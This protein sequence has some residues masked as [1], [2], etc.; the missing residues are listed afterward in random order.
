L[1]SAGLKPALLTSAQRAALFRALARLEDSGIPANRAV[2][3]MA[4]LLGGGHVHRFRSMSTA[5]AGGASITEAGS[6]FGL[7]SARDRE[8]IRLAER[9]GTLARAATLLADAYDHRARVFAAL[10]SRM[11]LPLFVLVLGSVLLPL[12]AFL[13]GQMGAGEFLWR[14]STPVAGLV[15]VAGLVTRLLRRTA[16]RGVSPAGG[17][18]LLWLPVLSQALAQVNR[19][20]LTEGLT[21]LLHAGV[22]VKEALQGAL[23]SLTNPAARSVYAPALPRLEEAGLSRALSSV[24]VL[25]ADEFAVAW[26]SEQ[27]GR[28]VEGLEWVAGKLRSRFEYRLDLLSEWLPRAVYLAVV[29]FLAAGLIG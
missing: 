28:L 13:A 18:R 22:P 17:R 27:A 29:A 20:E 16:A 19:L 12:P 21:L 7:F 14:A 4:D 26:T 11:M 1:A 2:A 15:L 25:E 6:R 10:R 8:L 23:D 5:I 9:S 24:G 3:A